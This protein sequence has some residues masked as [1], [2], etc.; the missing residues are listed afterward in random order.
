MPEYLGDALFE[1][2][3]NVA[4]LRAGMLEAEG[5]VSRSTRSMQGELARNVG[6]FSRGL[7]NMGHQLTRTLTFPI[8]GIGVAA[9][10]M[11]IDFQAAMENIHTQAGASQREVDL[12]SKKVLALA[13]TVP[14]GPTPLADALYHLESI[15]LR[16]TRSFEQQGLQVRKQIP[17]MQVLKT[18]AEGAAIG[19]SDLEQTTTALGSAWLSGIKGATNLKTAMGTLNAIVG[20]GNMRMQDLVSALGTGVLPMAKLAGLGFKDVGAALAIMSDEGYNVSSAA[21]QMGTALHYLFDPT[22]K[23]STALQQIGIH[24]GEL[25]QDMHKPKGL[26]V[27]LTDLKSHLDKAFPP[28]SGHALTAAQTAKAVDTFGTSLEKSGVH[29]KKLTDALDKYKSKLKELGSAETAQEAVLGDIFPAGRGRV[30]LVLMNQ[31]ENYR[32]K[33]KQV[34]DN[35]KKFGQDQVATHETAAYKIHRAWASIE[36]DL[37][38]F[39]QNVLPPLLDGVKGVADEVDKVGKAFERLDPQTKKMIITGGLVVAAIGPAMRIASFFHGRRLQAL[40]RGD[41]C[42][43]ARHG[44]PALRAGIREK[45]QADR[46]G[47]S[48]RHRQMQVNQMIVAELI[49]K[50]IPGLPGSRGGGGVPRASG[51]SPR[52]PSRGA[53][54]AA[55]GRSR[56]CAAQATCT[57]PCSGATSGWP[58]L[59]EAIGEGGD[60]RGGDEGGD[61]DRHGSGPAR[62]RHER[63]ADRAA[64][65]RE[66]HPERGQRS[67]GRRDEGRDGRVLSRKHGCTENPI[68]HGR[69]QAGQDR[70]D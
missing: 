3:A 14:Y 7:G 56:G 57:T 30:L 62:D 47:Q 22:Q 5:I 34:N 38:S 21:T 17:L 18:A 1:L 32:S 46:C 55:E 24:A 59:A 49:A 60:R 52:T 68:G 61:A 44:R 53:A 15:G 41:H 40:G 9:G 64:A 67:G 31:L 48:R 26:L 63:P 16:L 2:R 23:A 42:R 66:A 65:D 13:K 8:L 28:S 36:S 4:P 58:A 12:L 20:T 33:L 54:A 45:R 11:A 43:P 35:E 70:T 50:N 25:S 29:G 69:G 51:I 6:S 19:H 37:T 39:G 10:K 27:A